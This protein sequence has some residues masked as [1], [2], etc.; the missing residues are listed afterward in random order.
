ML[1]EPMPTMQV[2]TNGSSHYWGDIYKDLRSNWIQRANLNE[3]VVSETVIGSQANKAHSVVE[4]RIEIR[5]VKFSMISQPFL[6]EICKPCDT[7]YCYIY[8]GC[9]N[10]LPSK[11]NLKDNSDLFDNQNPNYRLS[12][13]TL[14]KEKR[15]ICQKPID[16]F[17]A[18]RI[19]NC[20]TTLPLMAFLK[21]GQG[22]RM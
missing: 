19:F 8:F 13:D 7:S 11:Q 15:L 21:K 10:C 12:V 4:R 2:N 17:F 22:Q 20:R 3:I 9:S 14:L 5:N 6:I 16:L 1:M 18:C